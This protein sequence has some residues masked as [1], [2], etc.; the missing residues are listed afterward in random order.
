MQYHVIPE[1]VAIW[2]IPLKLVF[3][4]NLSK[5]HSCPIILKICTGHGSITT[6][7]CVKLFRCLEVILW[8]NEISQDPS[9]RWVLKDIL[10]CYSPRTVFQLDLTVSNKANNNMN[11]TCKN[12]AHH[13]CFVEFY[14]GLILLG[15]TL[16]LQVEYG[17]MSRWID[18]Y[19]MTTK[20]I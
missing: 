14:C 13:L 16:I 1:V 20:K 10:C 12:H 8:L 18:Q 11:L 2:N 19:S 15:F 7:L 9:L 17:W 5:F 6:V 4:S 3:N